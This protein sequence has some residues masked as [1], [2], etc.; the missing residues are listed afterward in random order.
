VD[1]FQGNGE[2]EVSGLDPGEDLLHAGLNCVH[3]GLGNYVLT[4]EHPGMGDG[5]PDVL[6]VETFIKVDGCS[7]LL[8]ESIGGLGEPASPEFILGH[9]DLLLKKVSRK[10]ERG[11]RCEELG[12]RQ[13]FPE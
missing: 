8:D 4:A 9:A 13:V 7:E 11:S 5:T 2:I 10:E 6:A 1:V 3:I 12:S